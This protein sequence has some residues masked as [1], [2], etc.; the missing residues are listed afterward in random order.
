[1]SSALAPNYT[2]RWLQLQGSSQPQSG[3]RPSPVR[4]GVCAAGGAISG[5]IGDPI[6][7]ILG[8]GAPAWCPA[9]PALRTAAGRAGGLRAEGR[10][11]LPGVCCHPLEHLVE[12]GDVTPVVAECPGRL[13]G[14]VGAFRGWAAGSLAAPPSVLI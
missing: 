5:F 10:S 3:A 12:G 1:M 2:S 4:P 7:R 8:A 9:H 11:L 6:M 14:V 13:E